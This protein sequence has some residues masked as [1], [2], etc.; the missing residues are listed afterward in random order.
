MELHKVVALLGVPARAAMAWALVGGDA[1]PAGELAYRAG[2]P[3][4]TASHHLARMV[5]GGLLE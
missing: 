3:P 4:Q 1:L 5:D 2:V